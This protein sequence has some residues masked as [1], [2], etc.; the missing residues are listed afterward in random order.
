LQSLSLDL[1]PPDVDVF[2]QQMHHEIPGVLA[3][4]EVLQQKVGIPA[5]HIREVVGG[6]PNGESEVLIEL[7]RQ[8]KL[9]SR[10]KSLNLDDGQI[11]HDGSLPGRFGL[12]SDAGLAFVTRRRAVAAPSSTHTG[13]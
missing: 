9:A 2:D 7:L 10:N 3:D 4:V 1:S 13:A 8:R 6:P 11:G 5:A 12:P